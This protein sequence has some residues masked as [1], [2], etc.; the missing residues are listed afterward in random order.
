MRNKY[1]GTCFLC[2]T[3]VPVGEGFFQ[4][5]NGKWVCRCVNCVGKG[6]G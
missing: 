2:S 4:R 5:L 6:N 1:P 3:P